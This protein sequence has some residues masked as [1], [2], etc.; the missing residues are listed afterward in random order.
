MFIYVQYIYIYITAVIL[1]LRICDKKFLWAVSI[2]KMIE[3]QNYFR[4][5][6]PD[7][8]GEIFGLS[9]LLSVLKNTFFLEIISE[10]RPNYRVLN[11]Q[12]ILSL[13]TACS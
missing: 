3:G 12:K 4:S 11:Y 7:N 1:K 5:S 10:L 2:K 9:Q 13:I 6:E 8:L